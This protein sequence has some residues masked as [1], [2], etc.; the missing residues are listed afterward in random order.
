MLNRSIDRFPGV[1]K[2][3]EQVVKIEGLTAFMKRL[4]SGVLTCLSELSKL[5]LKLIYVFL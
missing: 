3:T 2:L 4:I 1:F 5:P